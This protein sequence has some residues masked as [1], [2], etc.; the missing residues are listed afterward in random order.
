[1]LSNAR[2]GNSILTLAADGRAAIG[3]ED[4]TTFGA[5]GSAAI[6]IGTRAVIRFE[7]RRFSS[8]RSH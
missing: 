1:M 6:I 3:I 2:P 7:P 8:P 5:S 4:S